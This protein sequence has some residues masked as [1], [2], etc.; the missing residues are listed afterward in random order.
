VQNGQAVTYSYVIPSG[1]RTLTYPS[2]FTVT[3][4]Y[5]LRRRLIEVNEGGSPPL[6]QYTYDSD[7]NVL[8]RASRNGTTA[9]YTYNANSW[10]TLLT[11]K[12]GATL[13]AGFAYAYDHEGNRTNQLNQTATSDSEAYSYDALYRLTNFDVGV[14]SGGVIPSPSIAEGY[15]LDAVGNW[16]SFTSN[17]FT[18][19]RAPNAVNEIVTISGDANPLT[20]DANGNLLNDGQYTY[21][22]DI[23]NRLITSTRD[24]DSALVGQYFYDAAGR[25]IIS[26][27][28]PA[29]SFETNVMIYDGCRILEE[30]NA[31]GLAEAIYTYGVNV[32]EALTMVRGADIYYYHPNA[33]FNVEAL[34]D[35]TGTPVERYAYDA[36]GEPTVMDGSYHPLPLNG[37]G[38]PHSAVTNRYLFTGRQL[39]EEDGLY[40]YRARYYDAAKGRFLQRDPLGYFDGMNLYAYVR[41]NPVNRADPSGLGPL[42]DC[43]A[44]CAREAAKQIKRSGAVYAVSLAAC[45]AATWWSGPGAAICALGATAAEALYLDG[46]A[47][48]LQDCLKDCKKD[49]PNK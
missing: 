17:A 27:I 13:F 49:C 10:V 21:A 19:T 39:D 38:T 11:H 33:L 47:E 8:S 42:E 14:L 16:I 28:S 12:S 29:G 22:Y 20:Y 34:T 25:R 6:T 18:Q 31:A 32:D 3:E 1:I 15:Q 26:L 45:I 23:E 2:G 36:Y 9:N 7:N 24:S 30:E 41:D 37:W 48:D 5:D 35:P 40:F 43:K 44:K 4:S 46:V